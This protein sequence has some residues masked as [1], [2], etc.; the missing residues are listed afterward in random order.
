MFGGKLDF[1]A[2]YAGPKKAN[3]KL[4]LVVRSSSIEASE[5]SIYRIY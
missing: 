5:R 4:A 2:L 3:R 1:Q